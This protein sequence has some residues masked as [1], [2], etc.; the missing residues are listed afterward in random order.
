MRRR[1]SI[2]ILSVVA[3]IS[4]RSVWGQ[5]LAGHFTLE[6]QRYLLGEPIYIDYELT[7]TGDETAQWMNGNPY[8]FCGGFQF[9]IQGLV[10]N[11]SKGGCSGA[12]GGSCIVGNDLLKPGKTLKVRLILDDWFSFTK[13]G[14]YSLHA[15]HSVGYGP[16]T[17][18][19]MVTP[20]K[21][22][23]KSESQLEL[24][25]E[26]A[27]TQGELE[28]IFRPILTELSSKDEMV[29]IEA[30]RA[31]S[32]AAP[33]FMEQTILEMARSQSRYMALQGLRKL[34]TP[35]TRS[36]M[37][38]W[39][40]AGDFGLREQAIRSLG[41]MGDRTYL[42]LLLSHVRSESPQ[43]M[44]W[45]Y[46]SAAAEL[47]GAEVLPLLQELMRSSDPFERG[48]AIRVLPNTASSGAAQILI[49]LLQ[50]PKD[51]ERR[52][53]LSG[54]QSITH[55]STDVNW[56]EPIPDAAYAAW[57]RWWLYEGHA[58]PLYGPSTCGPLVPLK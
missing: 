22:N 34:N 6:K 16:E 20:P 24:N 28:A 52:L 23:E 10:K 43:S 5:H 27:E 13:P 49:S 29:R 48:N 30:Q 18:E 44:Q 36:V 7:N 32:D 12:I 21:F 11:D 3:L 53:A 51:D 39:A 2:L 45:A 8:S 19:T 33:P 4:P 26:V 41:E 50:S 55:R 58:A 46:L 9:D 14:K 40:E 47:S 56:R 38:E 25:I 15:T 37:A 54:L 1:V 31:I 57:M 42:M 35:A 17:P